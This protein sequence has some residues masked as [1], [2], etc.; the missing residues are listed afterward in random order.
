[1]DVFR[2]DSGEMERTSPIN[3]ATLALTAVSLQD[4]VARHA[5]FNSDLV[6]GRPVAPKYARDFLRPIM[7]VRTDDVERIWQEHRKGQTRKL[8]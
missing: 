6:E 4:L 3:I 1:M 8:R 2:A 5:R 7:L